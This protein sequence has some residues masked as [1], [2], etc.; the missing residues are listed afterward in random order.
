MSWAVG[1]QTTREEDL[2][3]CL[4]W[5]FDVNM[6]LL[7][8]ERTKAFW[9][10]QE[11]IMEFS[12][13]LSILLWDS[14]PCAGFALLAASP[15]CFCVKSPY[16]STQGSRDMFSISQ[17]WTINNAGVSIKLDLLPYCIGEEQ[18][19][20]FVAVLHEPHCFTGLGFGI[21]LE[22]L[23]RSRQKSNYRRVSV[24][25]QTTIALGTY[26]QRLWQGTSLEFSADILIARQPM[27]LSNS[28]GSSNFIVRW[29]APES[30]EA[31]VFLRS[32]NRAG[33]S[34]KH[35]PVIASELAT[36]GNLCFTY[37]RIKS[38]G[39]LGHL[40]VRISDHLRLL[41]C[42]GH[43]VRLQPICVVAICHESFYYN[44]LQA[45]NIMHAYYDL[46]VNR[47]QDTEASDDDTCIHVIRASDELTEFA[48]FDSTV[49]VSLDVDVVEL[50]VLPRFL[51]E[52]RE[53]RSLKADRNK[54][55]LDLFLIH[56]KLD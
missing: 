21:F 3:Y 46:F 30:L 44:G 7:Y 39:I 28:A 49:F 53:G 6:P 9:R 27:I 50:K 17:G 20:V 2:A 35:W 43:D 15:S 36:T 37:L 4:M 52:Q 34:L 40:L 47:E 45:C 26:M 56:N 48:L 12:T 38:Q 22:Q 42:F 31:R 8:G 14:Q 11:K 33:H 29:K 18:K 51:E 13:D 19:A 41:V 25:N 54:R 32:S 1:R 5:I 23:H 24:D 16:N 55:Q 10:L